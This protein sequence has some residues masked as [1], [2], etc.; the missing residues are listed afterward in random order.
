MLTPDLLAVQYLDRKRT[1]T[2][3]R[4]RL[5]RLLEGVHGLILQLSQRSPYIH[6]MVY[7]IAT[8]DGR[9]RG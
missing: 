7:L 4:K 8:A 6:N 3:R 5:A 9:R 2:R 1:R